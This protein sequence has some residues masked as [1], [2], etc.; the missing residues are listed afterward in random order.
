MAFM[1]TFTWAV[2][3]NCFFW[4]LCICTTTNEIITKAPKHEHAGRLDMSNVALFL[5]PLVFHRCLTT[6]FFLASFVPVL[7]PFHWR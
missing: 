1:M 5:P 7:S 3:P 2:D 6:P 4:C